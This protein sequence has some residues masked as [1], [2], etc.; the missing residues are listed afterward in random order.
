MKNLWIYRKLKQKRNSM[1]TNSINQLTAKIKT[2]VPIS[3]II[4][5]YLT[6]KNSGVNKISLCP[7][8]SDSQP[9]MHIND[10]KQIFKCFACDA[11]GDAIDFV[12]KYRN[13]RLENAINEIMSKIGIESNY[14]SLE[15][16]MLTLYPPIKDRY[17]FIYVSKKENY[18]IL[19]SPKLFY[20]FDP[21][22]VF[23]EMI[24]YPNMDAT[25]KLIQFN[26]IC[27]GGTILA[28]HPDGSTTILA[29]LAKEFYR[30]RRF[31]LEMLGV[32]E[33]KYDD[34]CFFQIW[35]NLL[36]FIKPKLIKYFFRSY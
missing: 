3:S 18:E 31:T 9:S 15:D 6:I 10:N 30:G 27:N 21:D 13:L 11:T 1:N 34:G 19:N 33:F 7:F 20:P 5:H 22:D 29:I 2:E 8:H 32:K 16:T 24:S 4:G 12:M 25:K 23:V 36:D 26:V 17:R 28:I 35:Y 14:L